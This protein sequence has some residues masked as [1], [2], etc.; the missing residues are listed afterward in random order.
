MFWMLQ[1]AVLPLVVVAMAAGIWLRRPKRIIAAPPILAGCL[2]ALSVSIDQ[3]ALLVGHP[4]PWG[5]PLVV[6]ALWGFLLTAIA[7]HRALYRVVPTACAVAASL[8]AAAQ[9]RDAEDRVTEA[10]AARQAAAQATRTA[11]SDCHARLADNERV[12]TNLREQW[13]AGH[14]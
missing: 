6:L 14:G 10:I 1:L 9:A 8:D 11:M 7:Y 3:T 4:V 2:L 5:K 12:L 13:E